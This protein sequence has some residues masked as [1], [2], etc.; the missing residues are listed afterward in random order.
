MW[1]TKDIIRRFNSRSTKKK[2]HTGGRLEMIAASTT[3]RDD[4]VSLREN[5][6]ENPSSALFNGGTKDST[7]ISP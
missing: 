1:Q 3:T 2:P 5:D 6:G 4:V 7:V